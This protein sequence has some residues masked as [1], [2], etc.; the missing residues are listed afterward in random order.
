M[1]RTH[2]TSPWQYIMVC[3]VKAVLFSQVVSPSCFYMLFLVL[4]LCMIWI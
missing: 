2:V 3:V 1:L 4:V